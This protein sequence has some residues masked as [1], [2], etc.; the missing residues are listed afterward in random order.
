M[1]NRKSIKAI[2]NPTKSEMADAYYPNV[3]LH[4]SLRKG[5]YQVF[6]HV[7]FSAAKL[8]YGNNFDEPFDTQLDEMTTILQARLKDMSIIVSLDDLKYAQVVGIHYGKNVSLTDGSLPFDI[9][10]KFGQIDQ[11]LW[12]DEAKVIYGNGGLSFKLH[13]NAWELIIYDKRK[14]LEQ[15]KRSERKAIS[16]GNYTQ[17]D[18]FEKLPEGL[19]FEVIRIELRLNNTKAIRQHLERAGVDRQQVPELTLIGLFDDFIAMRLLL[20]YLERLE[21][22]YP[23]VHRHTQTKPLNLLTELRINN[24]DS[25]LETILAGVAYSQLLD[26]LSSVREIRSALGPKGAKQWPALKKRLSQLSTNHTEKDAFEIIRH[27]II[28]GDRLR[29]KDYYLDRTTR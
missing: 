2:C 29:M 27:S 6:L 9:I 18:L 21:A 1:G 10:H 17:L 24:P 3:T 26:R 23:D 12:L 20:H 8:L 4:K 16:K 25:R 11:S 13:T 15:A 14:D 5:G 19:R 7:Q 28:E 22:S